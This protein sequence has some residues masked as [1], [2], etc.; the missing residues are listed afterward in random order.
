MDSLSE[1]FVNLDIRRCLKT[2]PLPKVVLVAE[3]LSV[4]LFAS[5]LAEVTWQ[6]F[7][8]DMEIP[9][10]NNHSSRQIQND[11]KTESYPELAL[12][13]LFGEPVDESEQVAVVNI[14]DI[15]RSTMQ[16]RITGIISHPDEQ[17]SLAII[18]SGGQERGYRPG[19]RIH[20]T[21]ADIQMIYPDRVV[22]DNNGQQEALLLYPNEPDRP[23]P[24]NAV[25]KTQDV[26]Q[27][28]EQLLAN[29]QSLLE[30]ISISPVREGGELRGYRINPRRNPEL[31]NNLGLQPN[32]LAVSINGSDLT[33]N[34]EAMQV[35]AE[36]PNARHIVLTV[37]RE[38][39]LV[40][41][42]ISL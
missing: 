36:L 32:D 41:I 27:V 35:F 34:Q 16:A 1:K 25:A 29:P 14:Q 13:N 5:I 4:V 23:M 22:V 28:R 2:I 20:R 33:N 15:P 18:V 17:K 30:L 39:Q 40:N 3:L 7:G 24:T 6:V 31:F 10:W 11:S 12:L 42:E 21:D 8:S 26:S 38:Q 19:E 37:E 9:Y